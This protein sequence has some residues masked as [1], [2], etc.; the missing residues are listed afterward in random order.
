MQKTPST[1]LNILLSK[2]IFYI[3][4]LFVV[5]WLNT[6]WNGRLATG[7][8][9]RDINYYPV[10][11]TQTAY[12]YTRT[13]R[14]DQGWNIEDWNYRWGH[15]DVCLITTPLQ[16]RNLLQNS[17]ISREINQMRQNLRVDHEYNNRCVDI[18]G[19]HTHGKLT[20]V[21]TDRER[22]LLLYS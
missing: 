7:L 19:L 9:I 21:L 18:L 20:V 14:M 3:P 2:K 22:F 5:S 12:T 17:I 15:M 8:H 16:N 10:Y 4:A 11:L 13:D 6:S 1:I